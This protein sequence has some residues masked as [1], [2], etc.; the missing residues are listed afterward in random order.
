MNKQFQLG[1]SLLEIS[2]I[3]MYGFWLDYAKPKYRE[4]QHYNKCME[5]ALVYTQ[6]EDICIDIVKDVETKNNTSNYELERPLPRI[7]SKKVIGLITKRIQ[8]E[9]Q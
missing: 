3:V 9:K 2:K 5:I 7:K 4:Q 8:M 1:L 6:T